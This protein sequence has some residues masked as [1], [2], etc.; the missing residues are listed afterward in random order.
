MFKRELRQK[1][2]QERAEV[3]QAKKLSD[4]S[5]ALKFAGYKGRREGKSFQLPSRFIVET[6][7][8]DFQDIFMFQGVY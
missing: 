1:G 6:R 2:A 3:K 4:R 7:L 8:R 5:S